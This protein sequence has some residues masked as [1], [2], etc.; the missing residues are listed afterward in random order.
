MK[1]INLSLAVF[2]ILFAVLCGLPSAAK[3]ASASLYLSPSSGSFLVG[4][5][6]TV[7]IFLNTEGNNIN[8]V[9]AELEFPPEILQ[10]TSPTT[11][12]SFV[13]QWAIPPNYS[14]EK[15]V[16]SFK[17]G[18]PEGIATSAGLVSSITFRAN[19]SGRAIIKFR[20]ESKVLLN[21]GQ[22]T[23]IL[24]NKINGQYQILV[25]APE[26]P[27]VFSSTHPNPNIW[28]A[29][30]SPSFSWQKEA[31]VTDFSWTFDQ[32]PNGRPDGI[33]NGQTTMISFTDT[34]DGIWYFH[35]RQKRDDVWGQTSTVAVKIDTTAPQE[36]EPKIET[37]SR[38]VG[39][40]T[41]VYFESKDAA[42]GIDHYEIGINDLSS[43]ETFPSFFSEQ[44]SPYKVPF[45][46]AG[47][48]VIIIK[49]IDKAG[50]YQESKSV[51]RVF[52]PLIF[53]TEKGLRI[54]SFLLSWPLVL[55]V[56]LIIFI[57]L[58]FSFYHFWKNRNLE[59]MLR[60]EIAE[61][62]KEIRDVRKLEERIRRTRMLEE[63]ATEESERLIEKLKK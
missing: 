58:I 23:D 49:A 24:T 5:T 13:S 51:L 42:S 48:Y 7:S 21:D 55:F 8:V 41:M 27:Q 34:R 60:K 35:L 31:G 62:E 12:E 36:F 25:P 9:W 61:A 19:A 3:A 2:S 22:G 32:N 1:K 63:E 16:I 14:N 53:Y 26:G 56:L 37:Y 11:G 29:D 52:S 54:K 38:L 59:K 10:I 45:N 17:G 20:D 43:S 40:Q 44:V 28:Y 57:F 30:S 47:K 39:Y 46:N 4:S 50:N 18:V 15:G 33:S 6:F